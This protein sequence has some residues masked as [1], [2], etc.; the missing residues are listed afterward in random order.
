MVIT[1]TIHL[2]EC[3][4]KSLLKQTI[5]LDTNFICY[6]CGKIFVNYDNRKIEKYETKEMQ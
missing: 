5:N 2:S 1:K 3:C 4:N 6:K